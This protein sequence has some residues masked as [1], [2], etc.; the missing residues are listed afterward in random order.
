MVILRIGY[1]VLTKHNA[2][3]MHPLT[4]S[5]YVFRI[6][7]RCDDVIEYATNRYYIIEA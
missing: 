2:Y 5:G 1:C 7:G 4:C 6:G 3:Y